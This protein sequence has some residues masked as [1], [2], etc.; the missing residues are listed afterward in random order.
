MDRVGALSDVGTVKAI[1]ALGVCVMGL[2]IAVGLLLGISPVE[3]LLAYDHIDTQA[4]YACARAH[5]QRST[6]DTLLFRHETWLEIGAPSRT[7]KALTRFDQTAYSALVARGVGSADAD[8]LLASLQAR[9][10]ERFGGTLLVSVTEIAP[11]LANRVLVPSRLLEGCERP[12]AGLSAVVCEDVQTLSHRGPES[13]DGKR[14]KVHAFLVVGTE[15]LGTEA[16]RAGLHGELFAS[17]GAPSSVPDDHA[18]SVGAT[19]LCVHSN[20]SLRGPSGLPR[21]RETDTTAIHAT[22]D[23][24]GVLMGI[25]GTQQTRCAYS[26]ATPTELLPVRSTSAVDA[27]GSSM[28]VGLTDKEAF[29]AVTCATQDIHGPS[30]QTNV[31]VLACANSGTQCGGDPLLPVVDVAQRAVL[32]NHTTSG[33]VVLTMARERSSAFSG[34]GELALALMRLAI[35]LAVSVVAEERSRIGVNAKQLLQ[36]ALGWT[37]AGSSSVETDAKKDDGLAVSLHYA[38]AAIAMS[39]LRIAQYVLTFEARSANRMTFV[40]VADGL[41]IGLS[42]LITVLRISTESKTRDEHLATHGGSTWI[43]DGV[44]VLLSVSVSGTPLHENIAA[45]GAWRPNRTP[46]PSSSSAAAPPLPI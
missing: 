1:S 26:D 40:L 3:P 6:S 16:Q 2:G 12:V 7:I 45:H 42:I 39:A 44:L 11:T 20:A 43:T 27:F 25:P 23:A 37:M 21:I 9:G 30:G 31:V 24:S 17:M 33:D 10:A 15:L 28:A 4:P 22:Y 36:T 46:H 29:D 19:T 8:A 41:S 32:F 5:W 13:T 34:V 38:S 18:I 35:L 14:R